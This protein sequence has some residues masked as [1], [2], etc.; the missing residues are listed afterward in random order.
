MKKHTFTLVE[1]LITIGII[2]VLS[3]LLLPA[4]GSAVRK[5]DQ[6]KA[7]AEISTLV[8]AIKQFESTYGYLPYPNKE[9]DT[10]TEGAVLTD[11]QYEDLILLL[12]GEYDKTDGTYKRNTNAKKQRFLDVRANNPGEFLDPW[13]NNYK[14]IFDKGG[15]GKVTPSGSIGLTATGAI[16]ADVIIYSDGAKEDKL[17]DNVYSLPVEWDKTN[18]GFKITQ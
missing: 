11:A 15:N 8:N 4:I 1:L 16:Y 17:E 5:A 9:T 7:K 2:A 13:D 3:C 10:Y 12:Q 14:I 6:T 18:N